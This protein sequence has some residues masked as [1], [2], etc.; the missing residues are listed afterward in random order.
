MA[1]Q[2]SVLRDGQWVTETVNIQDALKAS[3]APKATPS[4]PRPEPPKC[5]VVS[6]TLIESPVVNRIYPVRIRSESHN[7]IAFVGVSLGL[8]YHFPCFQN[9]LSAL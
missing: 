6:R 9:L 1:F 4:A 3:I 7:D 5:G 2:S 8:C